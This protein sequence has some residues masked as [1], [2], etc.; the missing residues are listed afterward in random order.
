MKFF[1]KLFL[2]LLVI[3]LLLQLVPRPAKNEAAATSFADITA[4]H[5][6]PADVQQILKTSCYDC[7]SNNTTYPWYSKIQ[8]VAWWLGD[9][10]EDGKKELN[11]SE[12][13]QYRLARQYHK[14]EEINEQVK[15]NEMP[16]KSYTLIHTDAKLSNDQKLQIANWTVAA[17]NAMKTKYPADSLIRKKR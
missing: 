16:L 7:H 1:K 8:P 13:S 17:M 4:S 10:I 5:N 2:A 9:H 3:L 14:L 12:F 15:E 11:F 6:I